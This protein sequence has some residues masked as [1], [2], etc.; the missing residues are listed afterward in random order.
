MKRIIITNII[1]IVMLMVTVQ[2]NAR[3]IV[4]QT[5][6][7]II[8]TSESI[9]YSKN[10]ERS[11]TIAYGE[12]DKQ[13]K[14]YKNTTKHG[15][16]YLVRND[17]FEVRY[18]NT[19]DGFGVRK[20]RNSQM[21]VDQLINSAVVSDVQMK[22]QSVLSPVKLEEEKVLNYIASFVPFL[23]NENYSHILN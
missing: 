4:K 10:F 22:Q 6:S 11:W 5:D 18:I 14:V 16:E 2:L 23:L 13:I 9:E 21:M 19:N 7:F 3:E 1:A 8:T 20:M 17:F 12:A 15:D